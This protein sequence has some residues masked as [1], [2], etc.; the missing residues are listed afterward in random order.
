MFSEIKNWLIQ[1]FFYLLCAEYSSLLISVVH[2]IYVMVPPQLIKGPPPWLV[3]VCLPACLHET[4]QLPL[5][6]YSW[7][8]IFDRCVKIYQ[9]ISVSVTIGQNNRHLTR[10]PNAFLR[11]S[12]CLL[13]HWWELMV[14]TM[15]VKPLPSHTLETVGLI[16]YVLILITYSYNHRAKFAWKMLVGR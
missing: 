4:T 16:H 2:K 3:S 10:S 12:H 11:I 13:F 7:Q 6:G 8:F 9:H 1:R 14:V 5:D 15:G